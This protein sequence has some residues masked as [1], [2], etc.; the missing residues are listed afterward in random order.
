ME[1]LRQQGFLAFPWP[2]RTGTR[3]QSAAGSSDVR[4]RSAQDAGVVAHELGHIWFRDW[5]DGGRPRQP[6]QRQYGSTAPDWLDET[7]A[8]LNE[9]DYLTTQRRSGLA[10]LLDAEGPR[11]RPLAEFLTMAHPTANAARI[12]EQLN[13]PPG[14]VRSDGAIRLDPNNLPPGFTRRPDGSIMFPGQPGAPGGP[15]APPGGG[16]MTMT[17]PGKANPD[18]LRAG[19]PFYIQARAFIDFLTEKTGNA[20]I[21]GEIATALRGG[22]SFEQWLAA[23]GERHRLPSSMAGFTTAWEAWLQSKAPGSPPSRARIS[24]TNIASRDTNET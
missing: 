16:M 20:K 10:D 5:Y 3:L 19:L 17:V 18:A 15:G 13:L 4:D 8:V 24:S 14:S 1:F 12:A 22:S 23:N 2:E 9:N 21:M 6:G 11:L 7:A